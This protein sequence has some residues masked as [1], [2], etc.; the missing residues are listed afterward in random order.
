MLSPRKLPVSNYAGTVSSEQPYLD[1]PGSAAVFIRGDRYLLNRDITH[2]PFVPTLEKSKPQPLFYN[3]SGIA[4]ELIKNTTSPVL[5]WFP[6]AGLIKMQ[7]ATS[8]KPIALLSDSGSRLLSMSG[9]P[10]LLTD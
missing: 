9:I 7:F 5:A 6:G 1:T 8:T 10:I 2:E 4:G 3:P